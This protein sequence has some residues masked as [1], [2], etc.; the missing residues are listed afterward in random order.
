[1]ELLETP[2]PSPMYKV[3][4]WT[5]KLV[6]QAETVRDGNR[7][8]K[9]WG[10][11]WMEIM[12]IKGVRGGGGGL[13]GKFHFKFPFCFSEYFLNYKGI[14]QAYQPYMYLHYSKSTP[15]KIYT[16]SGNRELPRT[17]LKLLFQSFGEI[18]IVELP[19]SF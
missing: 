12:S 9:K 7:L 19:H 5:T 18:T 3:H 17:S 13:N 14:Y 2:A 15:V 4:L 16:S 6:L 10:K 8:L 1:M 11:K